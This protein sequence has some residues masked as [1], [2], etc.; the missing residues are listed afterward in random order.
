ME[1]ASELVVND[2]GVESLQMSGNSRVLAKGGFFTTAIQ[3]SDNSTIVYRGGALESLDVPFIMSDSAIMHV[4]GTNLRFDVLDNHGNPK[5]V[6]VGTLAD[7]TDF[8]GP[9]PPPRPRPNHPPRSPGTNH[10]RPSRHRRRGDGIR[11]AAPV[12]LNHGRRHRS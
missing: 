9:L 2:G 8:V 1:G 10:R 3:A 12:D 6:F 4:Y 7:G 5:P 11:V